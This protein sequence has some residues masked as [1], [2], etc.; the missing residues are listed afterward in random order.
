MDEHRPSSGSVPGAPPDAE[1][2][3]LLLARAGEHDEEAARELVE[4][5][6]PMVGRIV[7]ANLPRRDDPE[8]L[9]QEVFF[10]MFSRMEQFRGDVPLERWV[11]R[12]A[13]NTCLDHL[14]RQRVRPELRWSDLSAE[15]QALFENVGAEIPAADADAGSAFALLEKLL[16]QIPPADA[17]L[18]RK[19]ELEDATLEAVCAETGWNRTAARVRLFRARK[20]LQSQMRKLEA[21]I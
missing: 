11:S 1:P 6:G 14:R 18:L 8:D 12:I 10:R 17:W 21:K 15:E 9:M 19:I 7:R 5:L 3:A 16:D 4:R 2:L 20:R 13:V